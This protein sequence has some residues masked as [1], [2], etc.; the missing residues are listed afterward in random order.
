MNDA[1]MTQVAQLLSERQLTLALAE[2]ATGGLI[3]ARFTDR[4]GSSAYFKGSLVAY[5]HAAKTHIVGVPLPTLMAHGTVSAETCL[6]MAHGVRKIF[7]ADIGL[8]ETGITGP[9]GGT[10]EKPIGLTFIALVADDYAQVERFVWTYERAGNRQA[11]VEAALQLL[12]KYLLRLGLARRQK[13][14]TMETQTFPTMVTADTQPNGTLHPRVFVWQGKPLQV[15][16]VGRQW[17]EDE[18]RHILVMTENRET[19]ELI[20]AVHW[21]AQKIGDTTQVA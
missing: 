4:A 16:S 3:A 12:Q 9:T 13:K 1:L 15:V 10:P 5:S 17:I 2:T 21:V 19:F 6:G 20:G 7:D 8:A 11:T 18:R 14:E